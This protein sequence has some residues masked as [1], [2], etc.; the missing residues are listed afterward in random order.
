MRCKKCN[1]IIKISQTIN[2]EFA[3]SCGNMDCNNFIIVKTKK[4]A[5]KEFLGI[6]LG[7]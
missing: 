2:G 4:E 5:L 1:N 6:A 3:I 7:K